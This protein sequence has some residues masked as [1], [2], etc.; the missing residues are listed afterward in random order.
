MVGGGGYRSIIAHFALPY[1][2]GLWSNSR[3]LDLQLVSLLTVLQGKFVQNGHH[4][5]HSVFLMRHIPGVR[6]AI[7]SDIY[8][9]EGTLMR[10]RNG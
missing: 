9:I 5:R 1:G 8:V 2:T 6:D 4:K 7:W 3:P 10:Y